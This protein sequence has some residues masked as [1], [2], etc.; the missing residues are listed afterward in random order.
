[1]GAELP[2][3]IKEHENYERIKSQIN[4]I[5]QR[6]KEAQDD[7]ALDGIRKEVEGLF[8]ELGLEYIFI[9]NSSPYEMI[10][11]RTKTFGDVID[12]VNEESGKTREGEK[13]PYYIR[14]K[15]KNTSEEENGW[16]EKIKGYF[17]K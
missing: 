5:A 4:E 10:V 17:N 3:S 8:Q 6:A 15:Q 2:K 14:F 1:M 9:D 13:V 11:G 7:E 12:Y 16:Y